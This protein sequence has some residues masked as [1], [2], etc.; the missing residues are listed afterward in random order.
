MSFTIPFY[1]TR[2][3]KGL[4]RLLEALSDFDLDYKEVAMRPGRVA[5]DLRFKADIGTKD[6]RSWD[7]LQSH[8][9]PG[10]RPIRKTVSS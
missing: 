3:Q 7:Y 4:S 2:T 1:P 9:K 5:E 10:Y 6:R 8:R